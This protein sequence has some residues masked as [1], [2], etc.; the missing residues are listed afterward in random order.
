MNDPLKQLLA[1]TNEDRAIDFPPNSRYH[2]GA[3]AELPVPELEA[4]SEAARHSSQHSGGT[5]LSD[6]AA[7]G[8][9]TQEARHVRYLRR[10]F[11]PHPESF[12]TL[13][14]HTVVQGERPDHV[15]AA[16]LG[17]SELYWR[18]CDANGVLHPAE[19]TAETACRLRV[20]LP[21]G[22]PAPAVGEE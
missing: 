5:Y 6:S 3:I 18:L 7:G 22:V 15:A 9:V 1:P 10:R 13:G 14:E 8:F 17:D 19:L 11:V 21:E 16:E 2:G 4:P 12:S 20:T